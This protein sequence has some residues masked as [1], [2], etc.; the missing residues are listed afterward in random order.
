MKAITIVGRF[1]AFL[2]KVTFFISVSESESESR[3]SLSLADLVYI[4]IG[5][6]LGLFFLGLVETVVG[7]EISVG[8]NL[9]SG[10]DF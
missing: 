1:Y 2:S 9:S 8:S 4:E 6:I 3:A 10:L 5:G 7:E